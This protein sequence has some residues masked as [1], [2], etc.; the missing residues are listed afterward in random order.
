VELL[1][2]IDQRILA[3]DW[4]REEPAQSDANQ[5]LASRQISVFVCPSDV[6]ITGRGDMSYGIAG[7]I[8]YS[9]SAGRDRTGFSDALGRPI[10]LDGDG[11]LEYETTDPMLR[12]SVRVHR[13]LQFAFIG[14]D[15]F[16][17]TS[18]LRT[19]ASITDGSS[20]TLMAA[21][22]FRAGAD[23]Q[24][25][26]AGWASELPQHAY[27]FCSMEVCELNRCVAGSV[28]LSFANRGAWRINNGRGHGEG[29]SPFLNSFHDG[30]ALAVFA[31]GHVSVISEDVDGRI[32]FDWF[33]P[34]SI[35]LTGTP[36]DQNFDVTIDF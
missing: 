32:L 28:D 15:G 2:W 22:N 12:R 19:I 14:S 34:E 26:E 20:N 35:Q 17:R 31:D 36:F 6:T 13:G 16:P 29:M 21:E 27:V 3:D 5:Y 1:P 25:S 18:L 9:T 23:P 7:G 10:D 30:S 8:G 33:T 4:R 24:K 11:I